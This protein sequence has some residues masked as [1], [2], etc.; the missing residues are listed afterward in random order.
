[1]ALQSRFDAWPNWWPATEC[2]LMRLANIELLQ[3][4]SRCYHSG[5]PMFAPA[6]PDNSRRLP[7]IFLESSLVDR[8]HGT[9]PGWEI[10]PFE[11]DQQAV[12]LGLKADYFALPKF[13]MPCDRRRICPKA[14][15]PSWGCRAGNA[16]A[17][18][19]A[20]G[21]RAGETASDHPG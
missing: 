7:D 21:L 4:P 11:I 18:H 14:C 9:I 8:F 19:R 16:T 6:R 2:G 3:Q 17:R 10:P 20:Y 1:M 13:A 12:G 5:K 15:G